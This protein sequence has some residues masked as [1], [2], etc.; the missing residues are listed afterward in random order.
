MSDLPAQFFEMKQ[1][2][3]C[4]TLFHLDVPGGTCDTC[5]SMTAS[6][7]NKAS[8]YFHSCTLQPLLPPPSQL[9]SILPDDG[10]V[11]LTTISCQHRILSTANALG[12]MACAKIDNGN[13]I[14][15][16]VDPV[17]R[18]FSAVQMG[19]VLQ[20]PHPAFLRAVF[21]KVAY[22]FLFLDAD[23]DRWVACGKNLQE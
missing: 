9:M 7:A 8:S 11:D 12:V 13:V 21:R 22:R 19:I 20:N 1:K 17:R 6:S 10:K 15:Y 3:R 23:A 18:Y 14:V 16:N 4:S 5:I 2:R